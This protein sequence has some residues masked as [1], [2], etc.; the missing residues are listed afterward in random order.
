[1]GP[2]LSAPVQS[3]NS[4]KVTSEKEREKFF[5]LNYI[6]IV[7]VMSS[8][9]YFCFLNADLSTVNHSLIFFLSATTLK[10]NKQNQKGI[11][12][13]ITFNVHR[14]TLYNCLKIVHLYLYSM[15]LYV[16]Y[17]GM[18]KKCLSLGVTFD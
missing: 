18:C 5:F 11:Y 12:V 16:L 4:V 14:G 8:V 10:I 3:Q 15:I 7:K 6:K 17:V 13:I 9:I 1:M 2:L